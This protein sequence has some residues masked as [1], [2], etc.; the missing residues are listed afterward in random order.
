MVTNLIVST[1]R[2]QLTNK[3]SSNSPDLIKDFLHHLWQIWLAKS[4]WSD[5]FPFVIWID[6]HPLIGIRN[7]SRD[8]QPWPENCKMGLCSSKGININIIPCIIYQ[9]QVPSVLWFLLLNSRFALFPQIVWNVVRLIWVALNS[10]A[11]DN[12]KVD[13]LTPMETDGLPDPITKPSAE[14]V[15]KKWS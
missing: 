11:S 14:K 4:Y 2:V 1:K 10:G 7:R 15:T 13:G 3:L 9:T 12:V 5:G 8:S 6:F